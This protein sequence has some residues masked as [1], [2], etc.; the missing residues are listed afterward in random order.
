MQNYLPVLSRIS[1]DEFLAYR[2]HKIKNW[3]TSLRVAFCYVIVKSAFLIEVINKGTQGFSLT[4][5]HSP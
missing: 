1:I 5:T 2:Q 3:Q 4:S